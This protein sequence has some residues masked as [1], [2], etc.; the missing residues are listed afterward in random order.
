MTKSVVVEENGFEEEIISFGLWNCE[1]LW[2]LTPYF[3]DTTMFL[4]VVVYIYIYIYEDH[5][6]IFQ[7]FFVWALLLRVHTWN[8]NPFEVISSGCNALLPFQQIL[9]GHMEVFLC[10]RINNLRYSLFHLLN[11]LI[12]T[13]SEIREWPKFT[14][15]KVGN[16]RTA[17]NCLDARPSWSNS[18]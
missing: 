13:A 14:G 12:T 18:L 8:S 11:C 4:R 1:K 5:Q 7:T 15:S 2:R 17:G 9:G 3:S 10:E 6:I 16:I